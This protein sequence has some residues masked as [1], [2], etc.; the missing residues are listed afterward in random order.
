M[1]PLIDNLTEMDDLLR[2]I[3]D[4]IAVMRQIAQIEH[5]TSTLASTTPPP[6]IKKPRQYMMASP[7]WV[8]AG[9]L[10][11]AP[12]IANLA[13]IPT[14]Y[15]NNIHVTHA[16]VSAQNVTDA[17]GLRIMRGDGQFIVPPTAEQMP[18]SSPNIWITALNGSP[19]YVDTDRIIQP[20][21]IVN[22]QIYNEGLL[23]V[24]Y[25]AWFE[26]DEVERL[27]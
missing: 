18:S 8:V 2:S 20:G 24:L 5:P 1:S 12:Q 27:R 13:V 25:F 6:L 26:Y 4:N 7:Q 14:D 21:S 19:V 15:P 16:Y 17:W 22:I 9:T 10:R 3:L 23:D 11:T